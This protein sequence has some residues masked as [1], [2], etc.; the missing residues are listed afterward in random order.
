MRRLLLIRT[1]CLSQNFKVFETR[2]LLFDA[3]IW[4]ILFWERLCHVDGQIVSSLPWHSYVTNFKWSFI[5]ICKRI[6][7]GLSFFC[8]FYK[9][10]CRMLCSRRFFAACINGSLTIAAVHVR[11]YIRVDIFYNLLAI[12]TKMLRIWANPGGTISSYI[13]KCDRNDMFDCS[14]EG[15]TWIFCEVDCENAR[16]CTRALFQLSYLP[17]THV[18]KTV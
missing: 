16:L 1:T 17:K 7:H 12:A 18:K 14:P 4:D 3:Y 9:I 8:R 13:Q 15:K 6:I 11:A 2:W 10:F 5:N